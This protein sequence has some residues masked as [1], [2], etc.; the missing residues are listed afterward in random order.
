MRERI[1]FQPLIESA[2]QNTQRFNLKYNK[3]VTE[4]IT[5]FC[6]ESSDTVKPLN[7]TPTGEYQMGG[8]H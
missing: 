8:Q 6:D 4:G 2:I 3:L 7:P 5:Y 1:K